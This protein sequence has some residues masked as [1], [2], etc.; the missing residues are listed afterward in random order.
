M[1]LNRTFKGELPIFLIAIDGHGGSGKSTLALLLSQ[2]LNAEVVHTDDFA[3]WDN[4]LNW[5]L[6][7]I[8]QVFKPIQKG[9]KLLNYP[10][11]RWWEGHNPESVV[12]QPVTHLMILEGVSALRDEFRPYINYGIFVDTPKEVC[13]KRGFERDRG[14]DGKPDEEIKK[15]WE[16]WYRNEEIY[17]QQATP[18]A[19]ADLVIDGTKAL[20]DQI[21]FT[22]FVDL[23]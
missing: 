10:R 3:S 11:S 19:F 15:M 20:A 4:P 18:K 16:Q 6:A 14:Q 9:A 8:E 12:N 17:M 5:Y 7:L 1:A 2:K 22:K 13:L 21:D 23:D